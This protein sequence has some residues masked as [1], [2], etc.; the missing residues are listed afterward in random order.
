MAPSVYGSYAFDAIMIYASAVR[1]ARSFDRAKIRRALE[2]TNNYFGA[3][4]LVK[5]SIE[6]HMG[7]HFEAF[8][9]VEVQNGDWKPID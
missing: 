7:L 4:G 9:M 1:R 8:R 6:D 5:M 2:K 3:N